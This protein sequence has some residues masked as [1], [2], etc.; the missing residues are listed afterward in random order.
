MAI[1]ISNPQ[2]VRLQA[3]T[4][5]YSRADLEFNGLDHS[6][7]SFEGRIFINNEAATSD[8]P[9]S[10][11]SYAG[12]FWVFG[13]GGCAGNEGHCDPEPRTRPFDFRPEHQLTTMTKRVIITKALKDRVKPG[14]AFT[15]TVV[16]R[17]RPESAGPLSSTLVSDLLS[18]D[19]VQLVTYQSPT[20]NQ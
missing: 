3:P 4:E 13:H 1:F 14:E 19:R 2:S 10:D 16:P 11:P 8:T 7:A 6:R 5:S 15:I 9:A 17:M 18:F 12:S 20:S